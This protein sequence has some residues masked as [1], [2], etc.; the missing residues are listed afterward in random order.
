MHRTPWTKPKGSLPSD[1]IKPIHKSANNVSK[2]KGHRK[3]QQQ[4]SLEPPKS[5]EVKRLESLVQ[6]IRNVAA[7]EKDP[8]GGCFCLGTFY[9]HINTEVNQCFS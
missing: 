6:A 2:S 8:K 7:H 3:Q 4:A 1:R 5:K 9:T